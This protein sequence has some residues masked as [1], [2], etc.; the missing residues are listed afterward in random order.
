VSSSSH[1]TASFEKGTNFNARDA[2]LAKKTP[3]KDT[4][5]KRNDCVVK[6]CLKVLHGINDV[7]ETVLVM[8]GHCLAILHKRDKKACFVNTKKTLKAYKATNFPCNFM[9]FCGNW[10]K[11]DELVHAFLDTI[12]SGKSCSFM[13]SF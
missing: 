10:G 1:K 3:T 11:W 5:S 4:A 2:P 12:P 8:L 6:I 13:G 7:Q 9:D